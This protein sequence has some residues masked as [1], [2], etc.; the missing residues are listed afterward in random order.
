M[1]RKAIVKGRPEDADPPKDTKAAESSDVKDVKIA[2]D[3]AAAEVD[4]P[5]RQKRKTVK[6]DNETV[7]EDV[8]IVKPV[9]EKEDS[10]EDDDTEEANGDEPKKKRRKRKKL[11]FSTTK[12]AYRKK[13]KVGICLPPLI[14]MYG[15]R[16]RWKRS[17]TSPNH[18]VRPHQSSQK[19]SCS[20]CQQKSNCHN[21]HRFNCCSTISC[22]CSIGNQIR[23]NHIRPLQT[24]SGRI[25]HIPRHRRRRARIFRS[26]S[27][28][29]ESDDNAN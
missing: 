8:K 15:D 25:F 14:F 19:S 23:A 5:K 20:R 17:R 11:L 6:A 10:N 3:V 24:R 16:T 2:V 27:H 29:Y 18:N 28:A 1:P 9:E 22:D 26:Y 7:D 21:T 4:R 13:A 12:A